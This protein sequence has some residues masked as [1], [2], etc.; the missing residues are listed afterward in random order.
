GPRS[1]ATAGVSPPRHSW[2]AVKGRGVL[3]AVVRLCPAALYGDR[4]RL[5]RRDT[6]GAS[7]TAPDPRIDGA[8]TPRGIPRLVGRGG[9]ADIS[10]EA[11]WTGWWV[12]DPRPRFPSPHRS[13]TRADQLESQQ[14]GQLPAGVQHGEPVQGRGRRG[15]A[16]RHSR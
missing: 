8:A 13:L 4:G 1:S 3:T 2:S 11:N 5:A 6:F 9:K 12:V 14:Q 10:S 7:L 16:E 15:G